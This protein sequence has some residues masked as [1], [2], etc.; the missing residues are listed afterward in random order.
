MDMNITIDFFQNRFI[1]AIGAGIYEISV[2]HNNQSK[3]L[4]IGESV[5]VM[6]RCASHLYE[7]KKDPAYFG[8]TEKSLADSEVKLIFTFLEEESNVVVRKQK[9]KE[10]INKLEPLSQSGISD[11]QKSVEDRIA[12]LTEFL[13]SSSNLS[14]K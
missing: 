2:C 4:Y 1:Q 12:A 13:E 3:V 14:T 9:E 8:F 10:Y 11:R 7:L 5:F 6:V